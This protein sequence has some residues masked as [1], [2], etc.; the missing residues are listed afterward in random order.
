MDPGIAVIV[1]LLFVGGCIIG[2]LVVHA[3]LSRHE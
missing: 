3:V 2:G 1:G